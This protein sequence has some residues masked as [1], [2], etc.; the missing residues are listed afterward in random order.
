MEPERHR[1]RPAVDQTKAQTAL[2]KAQTA[3]AYVD[4]QALDPTEVRRRLASVEEFDVE[5]IISE[6]T[7]MICCSRCWVL[8]RAP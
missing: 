1:S 3:Q 8:S 6:V 2:V 4:M 7:R 5:D